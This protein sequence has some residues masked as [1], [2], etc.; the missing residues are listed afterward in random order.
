MQAKTLYG[1]ETILAKEVSELGGAD[2]KIK[3][4]LVEFYGDTGFMYKANYSLRTALRILKPLKKAKAKNEDELYEL[5]KDFTWEEIFNFNQTFRIDFTIYSPN[6]KHSQF[7]ALRVKDAIAD[8]FMEKFS[9]R[10]NVEKNQPDIIVNLHISHTTVTLSLDTSGEPLFKRGYRVETGPAPI[11]EVMA[12]GLLKMAGWEGKG[13]F[14]DPMCGSATLPIEAAMIAMNIPAQLHRKDFSFMHWK[15]FDAKLWE[16]IKE[17]RLNRI[18]DFSGEI[19]GCDI[20]MLMVKVAEQNVKSANLQDFIK[21]KQVNFFQTKKDLF[22]LLVIFNPPYG[23]RMEISTEDFYQKMG[24]TFKENYPNTY[25]WLITSDTEEIKNI[26]LKPTQKMK[27]YNGK[28]ETEFV[29]YEIY[30]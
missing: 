17:T 5:A 18:Q 4:R 14:L 11:N 2:V 1:F 20:N 6:F 27:M 7:A 22:P 16:K 24:E 30:E 26:G 8:R 29:K 21:L 15:D 19:W 13:N 23:E 12:A 10:P 3:N 25:V 28:I 9:K